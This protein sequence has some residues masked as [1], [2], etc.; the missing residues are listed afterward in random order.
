MLTLRMFAATQP[1]KSPNFFFGL[2]P[3]PCPL[4]SKSLKS[5]CPIALLSSRWIA[6]VSLLESTLVHSL[7]SVKCCKQRTY[8]KAKSFRSNTYEKQ[9]GGGVLLLTRFRFVRTEA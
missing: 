8:S 4:V 5:S 7:V 2:I 3:T 9:G 6:S 1:P